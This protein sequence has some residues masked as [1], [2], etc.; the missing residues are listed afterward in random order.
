MNAF[1]SSACGE[2]HDDSVFLPSNMDW[3]DSLVARY[4]SDRQHVERL[5]EAMKA[6]FALSA[7]GYFLEA[8]TDRHHGSRLYADKMFNVAPAIAVLNA[9]YW[10]KAIQ[11]T[12]VMEI[13]PQARRD[14]WH[15]LIR[16]KKCPD[17]EDQVVRDTLG[18]LLASRHRFFAEKVDGIFKGLSGDHVTNQPQGFYKRM[19]IAR[20]FNEWGGTEY[21]KSG[22]IH[23][24]RAVVARLEGREEPAPGSTETIL[25]A[26][27][28]QSGE[29]VFFD[30][31][32]MKVR[33][34]QVG[35]AHI[36]V[37]PEVAVKLNIVLA[38]IYPAAIPPKFRQRNSKP[39]KDWK[40][41][42]RPLPSA[43]LKVLMTA[44][45]AYRYEKPAN[46]W[47][48]QRVNIQHAVTLSRESDKHAL[49]EAE[50]ILFAIGGVKVAQHYQFDY[51][52][53]PVIQGI[54]I[55]GAMPD[56]KAH[57]FYPTPRKLAEKA[58]AL[59]NACIEH[60]CLEPSAGTGNMADVMREHGAENIT[61][62]EISE[63]HA[64]VLEA[65]GYTTKRRDFLSITPNRKFDRI[66]MNPP[67]DQGRWQAHVKHAAMF[68]APKGRLVAILPYGAR[69]ADPL[70]GWRCEWHGPYDNEFADASVSVVILI[71][72][73]GEDFAMGRAA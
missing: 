57:Q 48:E 30:G 25:K 17:F 71:A 39:L 64:A 35:T 26:A 13:M 69:N 38:S 47:K 40:V 7:L 11:Q 36:E 15:T 68:L 62:V 46:H 72:E 44:T 33:A 59:A 56:K 5:A 10:S 23:D 65:K 60:T 53:L 61:C 4:R 49:A 52:A 54:V 63:I 67:F 31:N 22:V 12:D 24:L 21:R 55:S 73:M 1:V 34:Y 3:V 8:S 32:R 28:V 43:V 70:P 42:D 58:V 6:P 16:E 37:H 50:G 45:Q 29:W 9:H 19:I 51:D 14:E 20:V 27:R 66:V 2:L 18:D 41:F